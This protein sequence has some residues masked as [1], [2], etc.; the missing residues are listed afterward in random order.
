MRFSYNIGNYQCL[1]LCYRPPQSSID[2]TNRGLANY[3]YRTKTEFK[4]WFIIYSKAT[5]KARTT[6]I[7]AR[8]L[9]SNEPRRG[10]VA[11]ACNNTFLDSVQKKVLLH[12][13]GASS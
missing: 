3:P 10:L 7:F 12:T 6:R 9:A 13:G 8:F 4:N 5:K 11:T 1:G 2:N